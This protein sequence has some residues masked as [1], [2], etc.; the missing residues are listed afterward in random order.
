MPEEL[1]ES[2]LTLMKA[3]TV[4]EMVPIEVIL[5]VCK[6]T[7]LSCKDGKEISVV[8]KLSSCIMKSTMNSSIAL[9]E[10]ESSWQEMQTHFKDQLPQK[11]PFVKFWK[12][13]ISSCTTLTVCLFLASQLVQYPYNVLLYYFSE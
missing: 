1:I 3:T 6:C 5:Q 10:Y 13:C 8:S 7:L 11:L 4:K 2:F 12:Q 9:L